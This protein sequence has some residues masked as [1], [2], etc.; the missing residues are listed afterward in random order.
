MTEMAILVTIMSL[1]VIEGTLL[2]PPMPPPLTKGRGAALL[3]PPVPAPLPGLGALHS[4]ILILKGIFFKKSILQNRTI[5]QFQI[6]VANIFDCPSYSISL[7]S[8]T[9]LNSGPGKGR[10]PS[11]R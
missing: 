11:Y 3:D 7:I 9:N 2:W 6:A 10:M 8:F 1:L 5:S 4:C